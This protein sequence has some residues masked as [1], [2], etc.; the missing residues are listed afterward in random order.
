MTSALRATETSCVLGNREWEAAGGR[1]LAAI[2]PK[3]RA[4]N[5]NAAER[6]H[7]CGHRGLLRQISVRTVKKMKKMRMK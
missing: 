1:G 3:R 4:Q 7:A 5:G 2:Q 6:H